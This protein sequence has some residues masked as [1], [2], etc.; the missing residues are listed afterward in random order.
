MTTIPVLERYPKT[1][2][3]RDGSQVV[4]S[5]LNGEDKVR[6]LRFFEQIS[7]SDRY[8]LKE[9]VRSPAVIHAWTAD[10][11]YDR[12]ISLVAL[13]DDEIVA[14]ATLHRSRAAARRHIGEL[15][16][17]VH[18]FYRQHG[19]GRQLIREL[20]EI[21][22]ALG[23]RKVN[24][25]LVEDREHAAIMAAH[26]EHFEEVARLKEWVIDE[27]GNFQDLVILEYAIKEKEAWY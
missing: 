13:V 4:V 20:V 1:L 10:I 17:V 11:D 9:D 22:T 7:P 5:L 24:F 21:A 12:V 27:L 2:N 23:L 15:R 14:D 8:Y 6:L 16:I 19:L 25:Q 3:L 18:P 26:V